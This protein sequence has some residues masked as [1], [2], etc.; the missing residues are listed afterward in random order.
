V[1]TATNE[2]TRRGR[3]RMVILRSAFSGVRNWAV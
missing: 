3:R 2:T 1:P